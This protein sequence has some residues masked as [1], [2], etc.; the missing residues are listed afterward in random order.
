MNNPYQ[1]LDWQHVIRVAS[2]PHMHLAAPWENPP[3]SPRRRLE[4]ARRHGLRHFPISNYYP[5]APCTPSTRLSD[6]RLRQAWSTTRNG[7][8]VPA[9][10]NWNE[11]ITW[12]DELEEEYRQQLP[13]QETDVLFPDLPADILLSKNAEHHSFTNSPCHITCPGSAFCSGNFDARNR[14]RLRDHGYPTGYAGPWQEGF[15]EMIEHLEYPD[16]GGIVIAHP[17]W[18]HLTDAAVLEM[19]DFSPCVLGIEIYNDGVARGIR[20]GRYPLEEG[21]PVPGYST[22]MWDRILSTGR[23]CLGFAVPDHNIGEQ[24]DWLGRVVLLVPE[25]TEQA[26]LRA[27]RQGHFYACLKDSGLAITEFAVDSHGVSVAANAVARFKFIVDGAVA[28]TA[29]GRSATYD[30]PQKNGTPDLT[31]VRVEVEDDSGERL[32]AQPVI[33][34]GPDG[35]LLP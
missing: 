10:I 30:L 28:A 5:S 19:L 3:L 26:C 33:F 13:F 23:Q 17:T 16:G 11:L 4:N 15:R 9:P 22:H 20:E 2:T 1:S 18:S 32:F 29:V 31:Y 8:P 34:R 7:V 25:F 35:G 14:F 12:Q 6:F 21:E 24:S 27:Y